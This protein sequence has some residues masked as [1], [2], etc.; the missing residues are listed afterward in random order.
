MTHLLTLCHLL[1][2]CLRGYT[3]F[4]GYYKDE[5]S[6]REAIDKDGYIRCTNSQHSLSSTVIHNC[7]SMPN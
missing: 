5:K 4:K 7:L 6:T 3:I 2:I 1:Q